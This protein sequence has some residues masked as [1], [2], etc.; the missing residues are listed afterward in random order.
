MRDTSTKLQPDGLRYKSKVA[1]SP[2]GSNMATRSCFKC[3]KHRPTSEM[4]DRRVLGRNEKFCKP[5]CDELA[6]RLDR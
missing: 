2:F 5:S 6:Q 1:G 4:T 3:G